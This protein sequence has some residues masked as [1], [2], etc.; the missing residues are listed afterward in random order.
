ML[1]VEAEDSAAP[2]YSLGPVCVC[3][4]L[5]ATGHCIRGPRRFLAADL[6]D[7]A[8]EALHHLQKSVEEGSH[9]IHSYW[10]QE[11]EAGGRPERADERGVVI[12]L[13][14]TKPN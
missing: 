11:Q 4:V 7:T 3:M 10:R 12:D 9:S 1:Y 8:D 14:N 13:S 6:F 2:W 5:S